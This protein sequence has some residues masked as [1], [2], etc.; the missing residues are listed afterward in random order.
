MICRFW[1][2]SQR[3]SGKRSCCN[4]S[5]S[6]KKKKKPKKQEET[7][8]FPSSY[9]IFS[10]DQSLKRPGFFRCTVSP[11]NDTLVFSNIEITNV[12]NKK[13]TKPHGQIL[14]EIE[15]RMSDFLSSE[16]D[17]VPSF[18]IR[19]KL[20]LGSMPLAMI[21]MAKVH[22]QM[23]LLMWKRGK[24][25]QEVS[26]V[27]VKKVLTGKG[28]AEKKE[29]AEAQKRYFGD[30]SFSCDDESDAAAVAVSWLIQQKQLP[31][32]DYEATNLEECR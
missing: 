18:F 8:E 5:E 12:D 1:L 23:D 20:A 29:V 2:I 3:D 4:L 15:Q 31:Y 24:T 6:T 14:C 26:P 30:L 21:G 25:W 17:A 7:I 9:R 22:G 27:V 16:T 13:E 10:A 32:P 28:K 11:V 19:E